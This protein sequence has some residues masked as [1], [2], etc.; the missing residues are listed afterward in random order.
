MALSVTQRQRFFDRGTIRL[1]GAFSEPEAAH[2]VDRIWQ[3][4]EEKSALRRHDRSTWTERQQTG[5]QSLTQTNTFNSIA[6]PAVIDALNDLLGVGE[7]NYTKAWGAPLITFPENERAWDVQ[8]KQWHLDFPARGK[9]DGF[10]G[11]RVLAFVA[12][13]ESNGGGTVVLS[14]SHRLVERLMAA[15]QTRHGHSATVRAVLAASHPWLRALWSEAGDQ[16]NRIHRFVVTGE[17]IDGIDVRVEQLTGATGDV[18][19]MHPWAFHAP[20][21][22]CSRRPRLMIGHSVYRNGALTS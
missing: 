21:P 1:R 19:L 12:P 13:V 9:A 2:I 8:K 11:I 15:G 4:L 3:Q 5:F 22:N 14:G 18:T 6:S 7:W 10:P 17:C 16:L 20:A